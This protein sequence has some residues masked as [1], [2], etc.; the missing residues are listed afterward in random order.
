MTKRKKVITVEEN[1][2]RCFSLFQDTG[3]SVR[4]RVIKILRDICIEY[5][6]FERI[7]EICVKMI[8]R[9]NDEESIQK[10]VTE[11]FLEMWFNPVEND[12]KIMISRKINQIT[13][14]VSCSN[15]NTQWLDG[16]LKSVSDELFCLQKREFKSS[17]SSVD[18]QAKG[19]QRRFNENR[20]GPTKDDC[21]V[22]RTDRQWTS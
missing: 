15:E 17:I 11:V 9:V 20:Q 2:I 4:K 18:F 6:D 10:L 14:V 16:L 12:N 21:L 5:P 13:D 3:V 1:F 7:P 22:L 8:R 19:E